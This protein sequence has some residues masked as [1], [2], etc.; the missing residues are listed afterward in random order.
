MIRRELNFADGTDLWLLVSQV[1]HAHISGELARHWYPN[2]SADV[3]DAIRHH[4]DGWTAWEATPRLNPE[5]GAP[6][7]FLEMPLAESLQIWDGSIAA[8]RRFGPLASYIVAGHFYSLLSESDHAQEPMAVAWLT[9]KRK[10]R[11]AWL[12][13]WVRSSQTHTLEYA[14]QAQQ[15]LRLADLFSL[16]L[17]CDCPIG[18]D[19]TSILE[20]SAMKLR[21]DALL[22]QMQ[23][24]VIG[25]G[26]RHATPE[27]PREALAWV[28]AVTPF[29]FELP[30]LSL[31]TK[32]I[33]AP[34]ARYANWLELLDASQS[35]DL[36][37]RLIPPPESP[38]RGFVTDLVGRP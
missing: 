25:F 10:V 17:C 20:A 37:W 34:V 3:V 36:R 15:M 18:S 2:F 27:N 11:T 23:L 16:W 31:A 35:I 12:D 22:G 21:T 6:Y 14:K 30:Q 28:V 8:A 24:E 4:D 26:R 1:D 7:S 33:A 29:P 13:E 9:E 32:A 38:D 5:I 19:G